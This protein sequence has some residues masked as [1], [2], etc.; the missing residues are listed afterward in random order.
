MAELTPF[1]DEHSGEPIY[2]QLYRYVRKEMVEGRIV[3]GTKLPSVR[4][5]AQRL[6]ISR[7]PVALAYDQLQAE[8]YVRTRPRSGIFAEALPEAAESASGMRGAGQKRREGRDH[9]QPI[10]AS[11]EVSS[12]GNRLIDPVID[13]GVG[14]IDWS[15]FPAAA[16]RK[17]MNECLH[18]DNGRLYQHGELQGEREL[19]EEIAAYLHRTRGVRCTPESIVVGAGTYHS[20]DL[21]LML[22]YDEDS[23]KLIASEA[24]VNEGVQRLFER[25]RLQVQPFVLEA[26]GIN[27]DELRNSCPSSARAAY[28][29][30]SHQY[31]LGMTLAVAK[32]LKLLQWAADTGAYIIENDYDGEFR[33][34]GRPIPA[35]QGLDE[36][37]SVVYI[38]TFSQAV[39]PSF[40]LS[41]AVLPP[42]LLARFQERRHSY[43][44]FASTVFQHAMRLFMSSGGFGRHMRTMRALYQRKRDTALHTIRS[45]FQVEPEEGSGGKV[46]VIGEQ[47]GLHMLIRLHNGLSEQEMIARAA[48][49][50]V[51][52]YPIS[53]YWLQASDAQ[54]YSSTVLIGFGG[55]TEEAI[56]EGIARLAIAW[57]AE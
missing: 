21:A 47:S 52:V 19:R 3:A 31:P 14:A 41:Y 15:R 43:D 54:D 16:W 53:G 38:G 32:R 10:T 33:Y 34:A 28:V 27:V 2:I 23:E 57:R 40:R 12:G 6:R 5:L 45:I 1:I 35:L 55:L 17:W 51:S 36:Q 7:T 18:L 48:A 20:L 29:T 56:R 4:E 13:F 9:D 44:Q 46:Q 11:S 37:G 22:I 30:P 49:A 39:T 8:G 50:G 25:H 42:A 26:D 24:A